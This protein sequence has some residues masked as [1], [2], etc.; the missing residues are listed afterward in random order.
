[1]KNIIKI[2]LTLFILLN[3]T[4]C[5]AYSTTSKV[6]TKKTEISSQ[7]KMKIDAVLDKFFRKLDKKITDNSKKI[8]V[9]EKINSRIENL[10]KQKLG[11]KR[12]LAILDY[13]REKI[14]EKKS[15]LQ[16]FWKIN[17]NNPISPED[18][19]KSIKFWID[20][21]W[22]K[23][24]KSIENY[25]SKDAENFAKKWFDHIRIRFWYDT[26]L[27]HLKKV[28]DDVLKNN[29]IPIIAFGTEKFEENPNEQTM[30]EVIDKW[31]EVA[32]LFKDEN[33]RLSYDMIIEIG[34][35]LNKHPEIANEFYEKVVSKIRETWGN[36][37]KRI[38]LISPVK[39][40]YPENLKLLK[41]P[42]KANW[43]L[44][45]EWHMFA[46]GPNRCWPYMKWTTWT[47]E[48]KEFI[49]NKIKTALEWSKKHNIP[50]WVWA[51]MPG[52]YNKTFEK[53]CNNSYSNKEQIEFS[54]FMAQ[55]LKKNKIPF[56][57]NADRKFYDREK[58]VWL[59]DREE[60]LDNLVNIMK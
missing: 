24:K 53:W 10:K 45:A 36:N 34:K 28:V 25:S 17:F 50:T 8:K 48:E 13:L 20:V 33:Y 11:N 39:R 37:T 3:L 58:H 47:P 26:P 54:S 56:A 9:L 2:I 35:K 40:S 5:N 22:A 41:I 44:M 46:A 32:K 31:E 43:Y 16:D 42:S 52:N 1:M 7:I 38:I 4:S 29:M 14:L 12:L 18:Y 21:D 55:E 59:Q 57:I 19:Q 23:Y 27:S 49:R 6:E 51:W 15:R 60:V 30:Q